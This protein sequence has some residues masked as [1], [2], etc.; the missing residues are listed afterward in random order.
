MLR[1]R[2][3]T[4]AVSIPLLIWLICC[5][6][7][8]FFSTVLLLCT[9]LGLHEY[10]SLIQARL[11]F[12]PFWGIA[13]G[14]TTAGSVLLYSLSVVSA[15]ILVGLFLSFLLSLTDRQPTLGLSSVS[16]TLLG[17]IY[18]GLL[19]PHIALLRRGPD[20]AG[21]VF[22]VFLVAMLGDTAGYG[23]GR[24]WGKHKLIPHISP[25]KTIEGSIGSVLG[26]LTGACLAWWLFFSQRPLVEFILLGFTAGIVA[27]VGDLCESALKR[28]YGAKDSGHFLPGH[29]GILDRLDSLLFPAAFIYYY[30]K[31]WN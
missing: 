3:L 19:V 6:P 21:W 25:G 20:G 23:V 17:V 24:T 5:A 15:V 13:W 11:S 14:M 31:I 27:Q 4:A 8:W 29:G 7:S 2:L 9:A 12:P 16:D 28:A 30:G 10:F 1:A 26:N 18:V 22:F